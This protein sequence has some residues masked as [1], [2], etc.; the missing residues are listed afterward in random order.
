MV[1][2]EIAMAPIGTRH[3]FIGGGGDAAL[4]MGIKALS[5]D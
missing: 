5:A 4:K 3:F 1:F 2:L